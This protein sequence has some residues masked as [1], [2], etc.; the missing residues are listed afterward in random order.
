MQPRTRRRP[1][2]VLANIVVVAFCAIWIF[3][4]Y[5][6]LSTSFKTPGNIVSTTPQFFPQPFTLENYIGAIQKQGF[7]TSLG[8]SI[9]V[10]LIVTVATVLFGF[11]AA[12]ALTRLRFPGR[13]AIVVVLLAVQMIPGAAILI[14]L[15][16]TFRDLGL[17]NSY[18]GLCLAYTATVLP[19]G[20][21]VLR[22][23]FQA[24]PMELEEAARLDGAGETRL[25]RSIYFPLVL[26]GV[27]SCA[28]FAFIAA[29][30]DYIVAYVL[31]QQ[32][33]RYT[34]PVW[35]VSFSTN[36]GTDYG[37]IV[38]GSVLF[39]VPVVIFFMILQRKLVTGMSAGAVKG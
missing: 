6:M 13:K 4:I 36:V 17:L 12:A 9:V 2:H 7:L 23:F 31:L 20:I 15:F 29:W 24:I 35:L 25:L 27:I 32:Q 21:V 14:P 11:F 5:W 28:V 39:A 8:N 3:P 30:N 16:L 10:T 19:F 37:G 34:L 22:G 1:R 18:L 38:A 26:P 33:D